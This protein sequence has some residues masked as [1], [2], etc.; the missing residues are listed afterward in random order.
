MPPALQLHLWHCISGV[1]VYVPEKGV[2]QQGSR[3]VLFWLHSRPRLSERSQWPHFVLRQ[4]VI[5]YVVDVPSA[6]AA[7]ELSNCHRW[8]ML[9]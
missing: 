3:D 4:P 5:C 1:S 2:A 6:E 9:R 7:R 8:F